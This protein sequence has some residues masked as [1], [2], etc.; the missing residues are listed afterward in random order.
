MNPCVALVAQAGWSFSP[1][2]P[3]MTDAALLPDPR[4][5]FDHS[6]MRLSGCACFAA[7]TAMESPPFE[8]PPAQPGRMMGGAGAPSAGK[9]P[10]AAPRA[11]GWRDADAW[12]TAPR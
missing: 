10:F 6:V 2:P 7:S 4:L 3:T 11:T 5:I 9:T 12:Q 8:T 1:R